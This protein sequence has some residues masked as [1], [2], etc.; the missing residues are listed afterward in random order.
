MRTEERPA[1]VGWDLHKEEKPPQKKRAR[2]GAVSNES[3]DLWQQV[4]TAQTFAQLLEICNTSAGNE[5]VRKACL[6]KM[7]LLAKTPI[8]MA[9]LFFRA[10]RRQEAQLLETL[11]HMTATPEQWYEAALAIDPDITSRRKRRRNARPSIAEIFLGKMPMEE[12]RRFYYLP[13]KTL[14]RCI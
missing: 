7:A 6:E 3:E 5:D 9:E 10:G 2:R 13:A 8:E 4:E 12:W 14:M 1:A 11:K